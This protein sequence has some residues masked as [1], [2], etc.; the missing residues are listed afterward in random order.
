VELAVKFIIVL[1]DQ[2]TGEQDIDCR[3]KQILF[4][5]IAQSLT[6]DIVEINGAFG[7]RDSCFNP[8]T[9]DDSARIRARMKSGLTL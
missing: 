7:K 2:I 6:A 9:G 5:E 1:G 8:G 4:V 3:I